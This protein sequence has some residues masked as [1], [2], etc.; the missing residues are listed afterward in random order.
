[1]TQILTNLFRPPL[2]I[3]NFSECWFDSSKEAYWGT[4]RNAKNHKYLLSTV[5]E[6]IKKNHQNVPKTGIL[7]GNLHY[8]R[9]FLIFSV[10][11]LGTF[12]LGSTA[13]QF[14]GSCMTI[15]GET[16]PPC[17][18]LTNI[19]FILETLSDPIFW[20]FTDVLPN[21]PCHQR[22]ALFLS[23]LLSHSV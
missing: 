5:T 4:E 3:W 13:V 19:I 16:G 22:I 8:W 6:K 14:V 2:K 12:P 23:C 1:M 10:T 7:G 17:L 9:F 20:D 18:V 11:V 21:Y 15:P